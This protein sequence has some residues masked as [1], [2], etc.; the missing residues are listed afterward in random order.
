ML[1]HATKILEIVTD[2]F[3]ELD[4]D[5]R[6]VY[7]NV[8]LDRYLG[9]R[10][11]E[12]LGRDCWEVYPELIGSI[13]E[14]ECR[15]AIAEGVPVI[16][17]D[18]WVP[19]GRWVAVSAYPSDNGLIIFSR[20][21]TEH[22]HAEQALRASEERFRSYFELGLIGM[23]ITSPE[24]GWI[25]VN[26][27]ICKILGYERNELLGKTWAE[28]THPDDLAADVANFERV[29]TGECDGF[30]ID[31]RWIRKDGHLIYS[32]ISV[33]CLRR[34]D[35]AVDHFV[36]LLQDITARKQAEESLTKSHADLERR[37]A[38]RTVQL[39]AVNEELKD[40]IAERKLAQES[41]RRS[42]ANLAEAQRISRV[43]SWGW[44][45]A[46]G[47]LF[48]S[49]EQF[50]I[51][52]LDAQTF[53]PTRDTARW[54]I[55][56]EDRPLAEQI[57]DKAV[58]EKSNFEV[59]FR[60]V[61]QD[62]SIR[63]VRSI[64]HPVVNESGALVDFVGAFMD[65]TER[66]LAELESLALK[67]ALA[68]ELEAMTRLHEFSTR[69]MANTELRPLLEEALKAI[70]SL[71]NADFGNIQLYN[72]ELQALEIVV[73]R[74]FQRDFLDHFAIVRIEEAAYQRERII[75]EDVQSDPEF[76]PHRHIAA[77]AGFRAM[78]STPLFGRRGKP[79]GMMSTHF[80]KPHR[81]SDRDLGLTDLYAVHASEMIE[82]VQSEA[83][84]LRYQHELQA[85]TAKLIEA[86]EQESKHLSRELHDVFSQKLAV[87]GM[88]MAALGQK[89]PESSQIL[90]S[91]LKQLAEKIGALSKDIHQIAR[92]LH[93]AI[94][95]DLGLEAALRNECLIFSAQHG[96][97]AEFTSGNVPS[98]LSG[99]VS[100]C[101]YRVA[102]E[103]LRNIGKYAQADEVRVHLSGCAGDIVLT[104]HDLGEG[105]DLEEGR[106]KGGLGLVIMEE[107]V[108]LVNG[109][110][111]VQSRPGKGT[112]VEARMP[113]EPG[114]L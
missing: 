8:A 55:H 10:R 91:R 1:T 32:T 27:E 74:G 80:R 50:R 68:A 46:S 18:F 2:G 60:L 53:T 113:F 77:S 81:P 22:K 98:P 59:E 4:R 65:V 107:R 112:R 24:K 58:S 111:S 97:P 93:P 84:V 78:Q 48:W 105:F 54:F 42:E 90:S 3:L 15:R 114:E 16:F 33:K 49:L 62:G 103:S 92:Q 25:E 85:L 101:L 61:L 69:L 5:W 23:A 38:E 9:K 72:P 86:Q 19:A 51:F 35:G 99:D 30:A 36:A 52:G 94:L 88:E 110:F 66:K 20:D 109:T 41:L 87:L 40:E 104:V 14:R 7:V 6:C 75:I 73:Q 45:V 57:F 96:I 83:A 79:L 13:F 64:G 39:T 95:D 28:M 67:D 11:E 21:V 108:R 17:E 34:P 47:E 106:G 26:D 29:L 37:V 63:H 102:Q 89:P 76:E 82:R 44:N 43:G 12:L 56:P 71:Q 100:L 31:K 70:I